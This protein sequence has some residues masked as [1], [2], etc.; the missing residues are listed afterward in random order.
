MRVDEFEKV[1]EKWKNYIFRGPLEDYTLEIDPDISDEIAAI[2]LF[3]DIQTV[4]ASGEIEEFYEGYRKAATDIL[5]FIGVHLAQDDE[6]KIVKI[7]ISPNNSD[8]Q[9]QL[10]EHIW[11]E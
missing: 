1:I 11:G 3:L 4:R 2:A 8:L 9:E 10:K 7:I 5:D 6:M